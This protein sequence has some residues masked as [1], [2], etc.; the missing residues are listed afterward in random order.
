METT[1]TNKRRSG[2]TPVLA[3][4]GAALLVAAL[5]GAATDIG[6]WYQSLR[7]PT[8]Q[9][10]D[11]VFGPA[12]TA[13]FALTALAGL[14]AWR[15]TPG[16]KARGRLLSA[17]A[18]NALLN[19]LWSLLFFTLKRPDWALFEVVALW[20]SVVLL[21]VVSGRRDRVAGWLLVP[22]LAWVAFAGVLNWSV[23]ELNG[24]FSGS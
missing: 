12:W 22:Y 18:L 16:A 13:I 21:M 23:V 2:W 11:W 5:G 8:W 1:A 9:P 6:P 19:I 15:A 10:P 14:R 7:K 3:A 17:Y 20:L 4:A 24:R